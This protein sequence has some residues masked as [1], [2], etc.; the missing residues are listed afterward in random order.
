MLTTHETRKRG[1]KFKISNELQKIHTIG[2]N[3]SLLNK[4]Y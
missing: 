2:E 3:A 4:M 1:A